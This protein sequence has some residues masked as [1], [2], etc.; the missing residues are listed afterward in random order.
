MR[1]LQPVPSARTLCGEVTGRAGLT[2]LIRVSETVFAVLRDT[3]QKAELKVVSGDV[4]GS[5]E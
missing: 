5:N 1:V 4:A 3:V 2:P